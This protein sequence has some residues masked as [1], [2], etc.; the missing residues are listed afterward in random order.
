MSRFDSDAQDE[1][2]DREVSP[3]LTVGEGDIDASR[4]RGRCASSSAS[5]G[6][7]NNCSWSSRAPRTAA[8]HRI[9]SCCPGRPGWAR[10]HW[11]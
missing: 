6:C 4:G 11:R 7:A 9:T 5:H 10:R 2:D 1:P 3:A 8:A